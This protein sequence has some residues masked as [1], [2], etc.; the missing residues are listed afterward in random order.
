MTSLDK[1][2]NI[3]I[4]YSDGYTESEFMEIQKKKVEIQKS[5]VQMLSRN[6]A[7]NSEIRSKFSDDR[8]KF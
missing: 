7:T 8:G 1:A 6:S 3:L 5:K 4:R 2:E